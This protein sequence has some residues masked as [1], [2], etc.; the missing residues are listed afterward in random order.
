MSAF[1][2]VVPSDGVG[3][4]P[5]HGHAAAAEGLLRS[6]GSLVVSTRAS[7]THTAAPPPKQQAVR[8]SSALGGPAPFKWLFNVIKSGN[9]QDIFG[10][11]GRKKKRKKKNEKMGER[12]KNP[13]SRLFCGKQATASCVF[14]GG[15]RGGC[16]RGEGKRERPRRR[17]RR[18]R[19][20]GG[21]GGGGMRIGTEP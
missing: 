18:R 16:W 13:P 11:V 4:A 12:K 14:L 2:Q 10:K 9:Y 8:P 15:G 6:C 21:G 20:G 17:R 1:Y 5:G 7:H 19:R 3:G